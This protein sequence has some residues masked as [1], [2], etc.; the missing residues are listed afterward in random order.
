M[1]AESLKEYLVKLGW[2]VNE[3]GLAKANSKI[4]SFKDKLMGLGNGMVGNFAKAGLAVFSFIGTTNLAFA[5]LLTKV[6]EADLATERFARRM[7]TTEENARSFLAALDAMDASYEDI[8]YMT[9]EE[10]NRF[11]ELKNLGQSLQAPKGLQDGL[12]LIRDINYEF[13]RLKVIANYATQWVSYYLTKYLGGDLNNIKESLQSFNNWIIEKIPTATQKIALFF[14]IMFKLAKT[15]ATTISNLIGLFEKFWNSLSS[16]AKRTAGV[17]TGFVALLAMGPIGLFIAGL[18]TILALLDDFYT[19][20]NGGKS[21][22]GDTWEKLSNMFSDTDTS[23][24]DDLLDKGGKLLET[25]GDVGTALF[26]LGGDLIDFLDDLGFFGAAWQIVTG[27]LE[28]AVDLLQTIADLILVITG[29]FDKL[30]DDSIF[31]KVIKFDENGD[32]KIGKT[33]ANIG[34]QIL[35]SGSDLWNTIFGFKPGDTF[36]APALSDSVGYD[37][38]T[39]TAARSGGFGG[40]F[41][42]VATDAG[43]KVFN[44]NNNINITT[45]STESADT[46]AQKTSRAI[47]RQRD[48]CDPFK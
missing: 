27:I 46:I 14:T 48:Q 47:I 45:N 34:M 43:D 16:G 1:P 30:S 18:L 13:D 4:D 36:Y 15:A 21:A 23:G 37:Y 25:L 3:L 2:D 26:D 42:R 33:A 9:P 38:G 39:D 35:D 31:R 24:L 41:D 6:S 44:Q 17:I 22:Y 28:G 29:N 10:Y 7:W 8:F 11:I 12:K 20:Q 5:K 19:W 32:V 40:T